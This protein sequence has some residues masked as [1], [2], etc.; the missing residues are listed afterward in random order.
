QQNVFSKILRR[1]SGSLSLGLNSYFFE[2]V[3][4]SFVF[5][6]DLLTM[7]LPT[8]G[9]FDGFWQSEKYFKSVEDIIRKD[10]EFILAPDSVNQRMLQDIDGSQSIS[11]HIR[12][13]DNATKMAAQHGVLPTDYYHR[14]VRELMN[15]VKNPRFYIFSDDPNWAKQNLRLGY[16]CFY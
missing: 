14:A 10:F 3:G 13:G 9:Y 12:H 11:I 15:H 4:K 16:P 8:I 2:Q 7:K 6:P 5:H 1:A